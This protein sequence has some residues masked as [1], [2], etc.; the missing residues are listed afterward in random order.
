MG[1]AISE[2][3]SAALLAELVDHELIRIYQVDGKRYAHIPR[4]R[5]RLRYLKGKHPRPPVE[6]EDKEIT[7]LI[8][9]VGLKSDLGQAQV[10]PKTHEVDVEVDVEV[11]RSKE[12]T[13]PVVRATRLPPDWRLPDDWKTWTFAVRKDW[14]PEGVVRLSIGFRDYWIGVAGAKG[15][16]QD[17][18]AT[19][20][21]W[22]RRTEKE[23]QL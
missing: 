22:V 7:E 2:I 11:K 8:R 12:R 15:L 14:T 3:A 9:K 13:T 10:G 19:W 5:Q 17:W 21:N 4:S 6:V 18:N 16:K 23:P 1:R 20:R